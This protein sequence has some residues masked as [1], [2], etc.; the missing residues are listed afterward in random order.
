[1]TGRWLPLLVLAIGCAGDASVR[2]PADLPW[3]ATAAQL[4]PVLDARCTSVRER[5]IEPPF[6]TGVHAQMQFDC[7]GLAF[8]GASRHA[9]LILGDDAFE[10]AWILVE[11]GERDATLAAMTA[12]Y[13][14]PS[15]RGREFTAFAGHATAWREQPAE[16]LFYSPRQAAEW[17]ALF[18]ADR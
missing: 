4:R 9:E 1:M 18:D 5:A 14:P 11:P 17:Q 12:A 7:E 8:L 3:F 13:G 2:L 6:L 16:L 15:H 10:Q